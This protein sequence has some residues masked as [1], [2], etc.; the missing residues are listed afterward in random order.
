MQTD[1]TSDVLEPTDKT[2]PRQSNFRY[3]G[4]FI[5]KQGL[6]AFG[7]IMGIALIFS[8]LRPEIDY[9]SESYSSNAYST[10]L[11]IIPPVMTLGYLIYLIVAIV[12]SCKER[13]L[14]AP[15]REGKPLLK[16]L[17]F[18]KITLIILV[19]VFALFGLKA[20]IRNNAINS[21]CQWYIEQSTN[22]LADAQLG[23]YFRFLR[24]NGLPE[25]DRLA[26]KWL[27][28]SAKNNNSKARYFLSEHYI[29]GSY[30]NPVRRKK[31][32]DMMEE[33]AGQND[34]DALYFLGRNYFHG[35][36]DRPI[37]REKGIAFFT[38]AANQGYYVA[39]N[40]LGKIYMDKSF[41]GYDK[42]KAIIWHRKA[43]LEGH[44]DSI[45][46]ML[47][48][49]KRGEASLSRQEMEAYN[50]HISAELNKIE[51]G[52]QE[53]NK[54]HFEQSLR[55]A[56]GKRGSWGGAFYLAGLYKEGKGTET[57]ISEAVRWYEI[58]DERTD[59]RAAY[60]LGWMYF[61]GDGVS[62]NK[63]EA[64]KWFAICADKYGRNGTVLRQVNSDALS[65]A[66]QPPC[67]W[68]ICII[69]GLE[70]SKIG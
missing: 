61:K 49:W 52:R 8:V 38:K 5:I 66:M 41:E 42:D 57:N 21:K 9:T 13:K 37:E 56:D 24:G 53:S 7:C 3:W 10:C 45:D 48:L 69:L 14:T 4:W 22:S 51:E 25:S 58:A 23:I 47:D 2:T 20:L 26:L 36:R 67:I 12:R 29:D 44:T 34:A 46:V 15:K 54:F 18:N 50:A 55:D 63:A 30:Y 70:A 59:W 64:R 32:W 6:I 65:L 31:G 17:I 19:A 43:A 35:L 16:K 39:Q 1:D 27:K 60:T 62:E 40:E 28:K 11:E 68:Q 33:L